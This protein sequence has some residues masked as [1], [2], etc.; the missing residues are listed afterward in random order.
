MR[1]DRM[2]GKKIFSV[3]GIFDSAPLLMKAIPEV[4]D[5]V[6]APLEA[7][8]PYPIHGM[9]KALGLKKSPI[10]GMVL[11]M[12][13]VGAISALALQ[14]W[15]S[16]WDYPQTTAG[17]PYFSWEAF[18]PVVFELTV[19]FATFTAGL[20]MLLLL[21]RLPLFRHPMLRSAS[22]PL[23]TRDKFG[24]AVESNGNELDVEKISALLTNSGAKTIEV[25]EEPVPIGPVSAGFFVIFLVAIVVS[26]AAAGYLTY[27][28]IK[29]FPV[30]IPMVHMLNQPRLD[31]QRSESFFKDGFGMRMPVPETVM[32]G[33]SQ[34]S[35]RNQ[36]DA[37]V[38]VNPLPRTKS[39]LSQ[40]RQAFMNYCSVCHG[41]LGNGAPTLTA[42]YGAKPANLVAQSMVEL[43]DGKIYHVIV[44]GKNAMPSYS[45]ELT[46]TERWAAVHYVRVLQRALNARDEDFK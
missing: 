19:L 4:K 1:E 40:G 39:I 42:A 8:T 13:L 25:I 16:G 14:L 22:L 46:D 7:Y 29:L 44:R 41:I 10:G 17:K 38:L 9:D 36:D 3:L 23:I 30:S 21:N 11:V 32:R 26:S 28:G 2:N 15:T 33:S 31:P 37:G 34:Y 24:L 45:I 18:V 27:W 35:I 12:G 20:G 43:P 6:S 5:K